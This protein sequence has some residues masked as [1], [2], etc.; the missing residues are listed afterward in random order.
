MTCLH[1]AVTATTW[2]PALYMD[3]FIKATPA[4]TSYYFAPIGSG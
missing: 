4:A 2:Y 3:T 1:S